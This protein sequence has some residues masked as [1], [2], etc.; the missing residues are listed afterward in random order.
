MRI[1]K[2]QRLDATRLQKLFP[3][4]IMILLVG[5]TMLAAVKLNCQFRLLAKEIKI[6]N[7][8]RVLAAKFI[9]GETAVA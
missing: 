5:K 8:E 7:A 9:A 4:S 1:P 3:L 6:V 2:P